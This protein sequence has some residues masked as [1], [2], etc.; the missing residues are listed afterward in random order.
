M[1]ARTSIDARPMLIADNADMAM[2]MLC[3]LPRD[4]SS[5]PLAP[6][7]ADLGETMQSQVSKW[8]RELKDTCGIAIRTHNGAHNEGRVVCM[9]HEPSGN[10]A[11]SIE[12][13][14]AYWD[15]HYPK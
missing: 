8:G 15:S 2:E 11:R 7:L 9:H 13:A 12:A 1:T 5:V 6:L 10:M 3:M 4:G 14:E